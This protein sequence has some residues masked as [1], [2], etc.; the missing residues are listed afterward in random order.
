MNDKIYVPTKGPDSWREFLAQPEMQWETGYS[1]KTMAHC[2]EDK[3]GFPSEFNK[4]LI[5]S[6]LDLDLLLAIPEY[7]V[8]LDTKKAPSQNDLFV[9]LGTQTRTD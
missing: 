1:A 4:V 2:W 8:Y 6:G 9:F 7:K 3:T 5:D